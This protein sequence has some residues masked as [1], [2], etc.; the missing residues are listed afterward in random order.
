MPDKR[1]VSNS[2]I[3]LERTYDEIEVNPEGVDSL[4]LIDGSYTRT[5]ACP[6]FSRRSVV[7]A[8]T[9]DERSFTTTASAKLPNAAAAAASQ[10]LSISISPATLPII[11]TPR[12]SFKSAEAPSRFS[13][14]NF[15][16]SNLDSTAFRSRSA[17][18]SVS[19]KCASF[20]FEDSREDFALSKSESSPSSPESALAI[21]NSYVE[22]SR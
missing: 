18:R 5:S 8:V 1:E 12:E 4:A 11:E 22:Y 19:I 14:V 16:A 9:A 7:N 20:C 2:L 21:S 15:I 6:R 10:P 17:T 13:D 3:E